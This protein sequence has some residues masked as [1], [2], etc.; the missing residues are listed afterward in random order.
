VREAAAR[1]QGCFGEVVL[2]ELDPHAVADRADL[3]EREEQLSGDRGLAANRRAC[4]PDEPGDVLA[5][6]RLG[7]EM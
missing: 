4:L 1:E 6:R 3:A 7:R 2:G 5:E